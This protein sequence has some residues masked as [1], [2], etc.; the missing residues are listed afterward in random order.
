MVQTNEV[1]ARPPGDGW[2]GEILGPD[3]VPVARGCC[4]LV[5]PAEKLDLGRSSQSRKP[6]DTRPGGHTTLSLLLPASDLPMELVR[7][8]EMGGLDPRS[9]KWL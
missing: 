7:S 1:A 6:A 2:Q 3:C 9:A 5:L 4:C 8:W